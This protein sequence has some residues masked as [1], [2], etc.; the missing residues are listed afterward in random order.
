VA[1]CA[2]F[3]YPS[4][5]FAAIAEPK[6]IK[7]AINAVTAKIIQ[8]IEPNAAVIPALAVAP[9]VA[10]V[11]PNIVIKVDATGK[12]PITTLITALILSQAVASGLLKTS[13]APYTELIAEPSPII[14]S[15]VLVI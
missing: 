6:A 7:I 15:V 12:I 9:A 11:V 14:K 13:I 8:P 3:S 1:S 5:E 4:G 2:L 10:A